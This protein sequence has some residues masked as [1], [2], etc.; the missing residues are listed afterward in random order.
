MT[1]I[2]SGPA[3]DALVASRFQSR[4]R[5]HTTIDHNLSCRP[6]RIMCSEVNAVPVRHGE[7]RWAS[8]SARSATQ[9]AHRRLGAMEVACRCCP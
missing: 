9:R 5:S 3:G 2:Q 6:N 1:S 4:T 7:H 8:A